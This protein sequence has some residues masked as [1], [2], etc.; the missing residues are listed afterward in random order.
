MIGVIVREGGVQYAWI[1]S[2]K[3][4]N[5]EALFLAAVYADGRCDRCFFHDFIIVWVD[6]PT[7][8]TIKRSC[9]G[10]FYYRC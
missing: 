4:E 1:H 8:S 10:M 2:R 5:T 7:G 6:S 9:T 3:T